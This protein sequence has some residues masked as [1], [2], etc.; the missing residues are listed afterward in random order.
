MEN[1]KVAFNLVLNTAVFANKFQLAQG[2]T[3]A[4]LQSTRPLISV[5]LIE[6]EWQ[7]LLYTSFLKAHVNKVAEY[8]E[9]TFELNADQDIY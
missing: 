8:P 7:L 3:S 4:K 6:E 2:A 5:R 1:V 9:V